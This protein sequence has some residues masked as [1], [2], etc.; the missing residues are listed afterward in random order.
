M[1]HCEQL[2]YLAPEI[3]SGQQTPIPAGG[4][5]VT[6]FE[7]YFSMQPKLL[8]GFRASLNQRS[9]VSDLDSHSSLAEVRQAESCAHIMSSPFH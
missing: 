2:Q 7:W 8:Y 9:F 1:C 6:P 4:I 5:K 3:C